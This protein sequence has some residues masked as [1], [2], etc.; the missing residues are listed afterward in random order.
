MA[1]RIRGSGFGG[2]GFGGAETGDP[3]MRPS[4]GEGQRGSSEPVRAW[5]PMNGRTGATRQRGEAITKKVDGIVKEAH[6]RVRKTAELTDALE[7]ELRYLADV[8]LH[9]KLLTAEA[10]ALARGF[11][12]DAPDLQRLDTARGHGGCPVIGLAGAPRSH[13]PLTM[14]GP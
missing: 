1:S 8:G 10:G 9:Q 7:A 12:L 2:A 13:R 3:F 4:W 11:D 5:T 14:S 6:R